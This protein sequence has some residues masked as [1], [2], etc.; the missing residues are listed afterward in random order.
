[1]RIVAPT[2]DAAVL[3]RTGPTGYRVGPMVLDELGAAAAETLA[4]ELAPLR[5]EERATSIDLAAEIRLTDL[6]DE[7]TGQLCAPIGLTEDGDRLVLDL[8]QAAEGGMGPHGLIVGATG[9][10]KSELLRTIVGEP[11]RFAPRPRSCAS[12]SSTSRAAPRSPNSPG[13]PTP[14]G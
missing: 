13:F 7:P 8:K 6:L 11:R 3:E 10:G 14:P 5:L 2:P 1:M 9:S 4:R 12:C